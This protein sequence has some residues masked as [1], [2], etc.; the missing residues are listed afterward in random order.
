[1]KVKTLVG[2]APWFD[3]HENIHVIPK[4][5]NIPKNTKVKYLR[6]GEIYDTTE[7]RAKLLV[8][9]GYVEIVKKRTKKE[10]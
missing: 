10:K 8:K 3:T 4:W 2:K 9:L 6:M 1:M 7:E 5:M